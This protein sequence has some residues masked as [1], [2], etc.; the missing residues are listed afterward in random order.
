[1][2]VFILA[3]NK[4]ASAQICK[5]TKQVNNNN[6]DNKI[7]KNKVSVCPNSTGVH[8]NAKKKQILESGMRSKCTQLNKPIFLSATK[9]Q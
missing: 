7:K 6:A 1:M 8:M 3:F 9:P 5:A 2:Y 4:N